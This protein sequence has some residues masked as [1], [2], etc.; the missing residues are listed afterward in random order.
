MKK[1]ILKSAKISFQIKSGIKNIS[2]VNRTKEKCFF[3]KKKFTY[4]NVLTW[5]DLQFEI[6]NYDIIINATSL[7]LKNEM[8]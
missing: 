8:L 4:L 3:L 2:I 5:S 7:S 1:W 6:S